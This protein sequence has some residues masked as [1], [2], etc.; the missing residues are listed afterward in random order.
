MNLLHSY[1]L[2]DVHSPH[3]QH[4]G[5][6]LGVGMNIQSYNAQYAQYT[7]YTILPIWAWIK[8]KD[9]PLTEFALVCELSLGTLGVWVCKFATPMSPT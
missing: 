1:I 8:I 6:G 3:N 7:Q 9:P 5:L 4:L 2:G